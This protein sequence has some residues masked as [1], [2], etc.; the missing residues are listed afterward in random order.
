MSR[1]RIISGAE[2]DQ[3]ATGDRY[4]FAFADGW[5]KGREVRAIVDRQIVGRWWRAGQN[6][7]WQYEVKHPGEFKIYAA[8]EM[9]QVCWG[10]HRVEADE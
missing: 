1:Y 5:H 6:G 2:V 3:I 8:R 4:R 7:Y 10:P 9:A